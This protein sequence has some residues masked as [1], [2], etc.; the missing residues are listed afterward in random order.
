MPKQEICDP[1]F[2]HQLYVCGL[3]ITSY[4]WHNTE[5]Y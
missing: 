5:T 4:K 3:V 1:D 2:F